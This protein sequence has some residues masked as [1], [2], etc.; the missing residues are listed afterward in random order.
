MERMTIEM[1]EIMDQNTAAENE[2]MKAAADKTETKK[3]KKG[4]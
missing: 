1:T 4:R 2:A 3:K